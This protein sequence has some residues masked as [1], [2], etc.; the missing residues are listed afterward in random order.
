MPVNQTDIGLSPSCQTAYRIELSDGGYVEHVRVDEP[1]GKKFFWRRNGE[2]GLGGLKVRDI[3]LYSPP[4]QGDDNRVTIC[5]GEKAANAAARLGLYALGTVCGA[6]SW[7]SKEVLQR[8]CTDQD[9]ILWADADEAGRDHM[10]KI[11]AALDGIA[12]S[13]VIITTGNEKDDAADFRGTREDLEKIIREHATRR[14]RRAEKQPAVSAKHQQGAF[15]P[16]DQYGSP[17]GRVPPYSFEAEQACLGAVLLNEKALV[18]VK[19]VVASEDFYVEAHRR[20][21]EAM[22]DLQQAGEPIDHLTLGNHLKGK[23]D[24][25]RAGGAIAL[26][27]LTDSVST[28]ANV[29]NYARI[30]KQKS[31][32]RSIIYCCQEMVAK[33]F[34]ANGDDVDEYVAEVRRSIIDIANRS[35]VSGRGPT[36][37]DSTMRVLY[38]ELDKKEEDP[39]VVKTG[40]DTV[41]F[42]TGGLFPGLLTV[43]AGRPSMGK[44][45]FL[46]NVATNAALQNKRVLFVSLEDEIRYLSARLLARFARCDLTKIIRREVKGSEFPNLVSAINRLSGQSLWIDDRTGLSS[47]QIAQVA[48]MHKDLHGLDLLIVD[49][50][51]EIPEKGDSLTAQTERAAKGCRDIA[52]QLGIPALLGVQLN[53]DVEKRTNHRP[54]LSDL[55]QSGAIEQVARCVWML[56]RPGYYSEEDESRQMELIITKANHGKTGSAKMWA[57]MS[58]MFIRGWRHEDGPFDG[59]RQMAPAP[60]EAGWQGY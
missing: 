29:D 52:K 36:T 17:T 51:G 9:V 41:D 32:Q 21:F 40:I 6:S 19:G 7:P 27:K 31:V 56:Y 15:P 57:D 24:L 55:R 20:I 13:V 16:P 25:Q 4:K 8:T 1:D 59:N 60:K 45:T 34:L 18:V 23:G 53:R 42:M 49:H 35:D 43:L 10:K 14:D 3:P 44:S 46:L 50:L 39:A 54:V 30:V 2:S 28:I 26:S 33:G 38:A 37:V 12:K 48:A 47:N 5:E 11:A 58:Q 22:V